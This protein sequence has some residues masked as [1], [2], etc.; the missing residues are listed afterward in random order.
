MAVVAAVTSCGQLPTEQI[1]A[2]AGDTIQQQTIPVAEPAATTTVTE[3]VGVA[4][5]RERVDGAYLAWYSL[6][7]T[8]GDFGHAVPYLVASA[9]R[10]DEVYDDEAK[11]FRVDPPFGIGPGDGRLQVWSLDPAGGASHPAKRVFWP[12]ACLGP[13]PDVDG[14][15][16]LDDCDPYPTDGP[17]ADWDGDGVLNPSDNCPTIANPDQ[18]RIGERHSGVVCDTRSGVNAS[19]WLVPADATLESW[20]RVRADRGL[21]PIVMPT[22]GTPIPAHIR[23]WCDSIGALWSEDELSAEPDLRSAFANMPAEYGLSAEEI[24]EFVDLL[25]RS[26]ALVGQFE[27]LEASGLDNASVTG[28]ELEMLLEQL[29]AERQA[30]LAE[31]LPFSVLLV[32]S[33]LACTS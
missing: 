21:G 30:L 18:T 3:L 4:P 23:A 8:D 12:A 26:Q 20:N 29:T 16:L 33:D 7:Q 10:F 22:K 9:D 19:V 25:M 11:E 17:L 24:A 6:Q 32:D 5:T 15:A 27:E 14:D 31:M 1:E 2:S 13:S 28:A